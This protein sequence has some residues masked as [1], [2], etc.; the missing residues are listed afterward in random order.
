MHRYFKSNF[1]LLIFA[2]LIFG[3]NVVKIDYRL[4]VLNTCKIFFE[5]AIAKIITREKTLRSQ[6]FAILSLLVSLLHSLLKGKFK[7]F[8][9]SLVRYKV[10]LAPFQIELKAGG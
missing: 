5:V 3:T 2:V 6:N 4:S 1:K 7:Q 9:R 8:L 10:R